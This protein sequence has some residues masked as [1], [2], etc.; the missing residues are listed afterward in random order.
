MKRKVRGR[1]TAGL[2]YACLV[3]GWES[4]PL[5]G[6]QPNFRAAE[7]RH[8]CPVERFEGPGD[9]QAAVVGPRF[10]HRESE[11]GGR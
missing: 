11:V 6:H 7:L 9:R 5:K 4:S 10:T 1:D 3:C 2:V 8:T